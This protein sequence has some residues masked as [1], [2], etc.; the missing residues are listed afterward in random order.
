MFCLHYYIINAIPKNKKLAYCDIICYYL[1]M[2]NVYKSFRR[3][4]RRQQ[5]VSMVFTLV[6]FV[7][8]IFAGFA[9]GISSISLLCLLIWLPMAIYTLFYSINST[10]ELKMVLAGKSPDYCAKFD[11]DF[12]AL[13]PLEGGGITEDFVVSTYWGNK[14]SLGL[15]SNITH[16][17][18]GFSREAMAQVQFRSKD[19]VISPNIFIFFNDD[20]CIRIKCNWK[21]KD[22]CDTFIKMLK[23]RNPHIIT[24]SRPEHRKAIQTYRPVLRLLTVLGILTYIFLSTILV[25]FI[26]I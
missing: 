21:E 14:I 11:D 23:K 1:C 20:S 16:A 10:K 17:Y 26:P 8:L 19:R 22:A 9:T 3:N 25:I 7:Q 13:C 6:F 15:I 12:A 5:T 4:V 18:S 24:R 2:Q